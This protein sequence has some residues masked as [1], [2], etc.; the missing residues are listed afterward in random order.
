MLPINN[1][2]SL[3]VLN[4]LI[5]PSV[6]YNSLDSETFVYLFVHVLGLFSGFVESF[7]ACFKNLLNPKMRK[8]FFVKLFNVLLTKKNFIW[9]FK[10]CNSNLSIKASRSKHVPPSVG[11]YI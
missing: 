10:F 9:A 5:S 4:V 7:C 8:L 2:T 1:L 11:V 6:Q 3:N